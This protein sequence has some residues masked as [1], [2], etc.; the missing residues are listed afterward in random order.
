MFYLFYCIKQQ[1]FIGACLHGAVHL[2]TVKHQD[3]VLQIPDG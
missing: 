1:H 3:E 2:G